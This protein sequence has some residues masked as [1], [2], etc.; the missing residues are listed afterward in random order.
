MN[1]AIQIFTR[2]INF[3]PY[4][5]YQGAKEMKMRDSKTGYYMD[6]VF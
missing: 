1:R 6:P 3:I 4:L 2:R 5:R